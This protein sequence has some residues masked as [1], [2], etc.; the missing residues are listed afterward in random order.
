MTGF[1]IRRLLWTGATLWVVFTIT[2]FLMRSVPG[3]PFDGERKLDPEIKRSIEARYQLDDP[4][5][6]QYFRELGNALRG[7]L[8]PSFK[9][10]D[11]SVNEIIAQGFPVSASLGILAMCVALTLGL[12]VGIIAGVSR[13]R[14]LDYGPMSLATLGIALPEFFVAPLA[15]ILF[16]FIWPLFPAA[17]WGSWR[18]LI[19]PSVCLGLPYAAYIARLMRTGMLDVLSQDYIRTAYAKG[20]TTKE[21]VFRHAARA[22]LL[23]VVSFL[24][25]ATAG[26]LTGSLIEESIFAI[27]GLG[28]HFVQ[29]AQQ[30]D[31]TLAM[32][33]VLLYFVILSAMN[34]VVDV[35]YKLLDPRVKIES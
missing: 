9:L 3:G 28:I 15:I 6:V 23:P 12:S 1:L 19:L 27:P 10:A 8:G 14:A 4:L 35:L 24:G 11:F 26:I 20:L 34:L 30:R 13:G 29:A 25:P 18:Q 2:F 17:G 22:A 33:L 31:Y 32:G 5:Y 16:V 21:I 7:D